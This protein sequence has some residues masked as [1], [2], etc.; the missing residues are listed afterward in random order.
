MKKYAFILGLFFVFLFGGIANAET[1]CQPIYGGG[2]TCITTGNI[3]INKLVQ[4]P[5]TDV[6]VDNLN[7]N[8]PRYAPS[9]NVTFQIKVLSNDADV[10]RITVKDVLPQHVTFVSGPGNYDANT[11]TLTFDINNPAKGKEQVFNVVG[12][13]DDASKLPGG[14][15]CTVNQVS[16]ES[17]NGQRASDNAQFCIEVVTKGGLPVATPPAITTTPPTGPELIPLAALIPG[18]LAGV[19][20]RRKAKRS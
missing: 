19:V 15:T 13:I 11:N 7:I 1:S 16:A 4:N 20:L 2:Q 8:D 6:F 3:T 5:S 9:Q 17:Q 18:G 12:K 10:T 14:I